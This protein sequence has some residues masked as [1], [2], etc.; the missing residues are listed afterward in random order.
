MAGRYSG[1][2]G[3][4]SKQREQARRIDFYMLKSGPRDVHPPPRLHLLSL[5]KQQLGPRAQMP[6]PVGGR[7]HSNHSEPQV[8]PL[9]TLFTAA[10]HHLTRAV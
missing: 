1:H 2:G 5:P 9:Q 7:L 10:S 6:E 8:N 4:S 3:R